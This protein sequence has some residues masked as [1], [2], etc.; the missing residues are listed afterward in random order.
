MY[1][2]TVKVINGNISNIQSRIMQ[3]FDLKY[4]NQKLAEENVKLKNQLEYFRRQSMPLDKVIH[5][6]DSDEHKR[7]HYIGARIVNNSVNK[8]YNYYTINKGRKD[9]VEEEM[10]VISDQGVAGVIVSITDNYSLAISLLNRKLKISSKIKKNGYFGSFDWP[11]VNY[12]YGNLG[13]IPIHV[14]VA[15]GD[16]IVTSG[17][18]SIF[19]EG[20]L[21]GIVTGYRIKGGN[22]FEI[23]VK[24][25]PDFK[26][27][28][29]IYIVKNLEKEKILE[30]EKRIEE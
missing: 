16:T 2:G 27:L 10:G 19:P 23:D 30:I 9:G 1:S 14:D 29:Q 4:T 15:V 22:F 13:E 3:Y 24:L 25:T 28:D 26:K 18:S 17:F 12:Q 8:Q 5:A 7:F 20:I 21:L 6:R 11:G